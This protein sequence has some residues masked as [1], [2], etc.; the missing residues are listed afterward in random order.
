[1][2]TRPERQG[3]TYEPDAAQQALAFQAI[4]E[5]VS[6]ERLP[7]ELTANLAGQV[8]NQ[9]MLA[10]LSRTQ[11]GHERSAPSFPESPPATEAAEWS[12]GVAMVEAG[13]PAF[14]SLSEL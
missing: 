5:G 11:A 7:A 3:Q 9:A 4:L 12:G 8:G 14:S 1:M 2:R 6:P 10:I 13:A